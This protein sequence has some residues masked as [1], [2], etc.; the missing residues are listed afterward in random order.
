MQDSFRQ[1]SQGLSI[2]EDL[3]HLPSY[4]RTASSN[5]EDAVAT[6]AVAALGFAITT[7]SHDQFLILQRWCALRGMAQCS[8]LLGSKKDSAPSRMA[9]SPVYDRIAFA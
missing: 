8:Q 6:P 7:S 9:E 2:V 4:N 5:K 1:R 3:G